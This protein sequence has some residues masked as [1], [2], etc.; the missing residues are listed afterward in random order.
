M[1]QQPIEPLQPD[2]QPLPE[3]EKF[4]KPAQRLPG[5]RLWVPLLFQAILIV[6]VPARD[7]Y[8]YVAG[9]PVTLQTA[10]VDPYDLLR[11]YYQTLS[12]DVSNPDLLRSLPGGDHLIQA[13]GQYTEFYV[14]L[15]APAEANTTTNTTPPTPWKP[16]R[17]SADRP[18]DLAANQVAMQGHFN[19][20]Q[21]LYGLETYYMPEDQRQQINADISQVQGQNQQAFVVNIKVDASG[22]AVPI[23][24]W[25]RDRNYRF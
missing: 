11:G 18:T 10:P 5:W 3:T 22:N 1:N 9:K 4:P 7:A 13:S 23:S 25:V 12:Y 14:V 17:I 24:L 16:V 8:T 20:W 2:L 19:G 21:V 15:E 6:A